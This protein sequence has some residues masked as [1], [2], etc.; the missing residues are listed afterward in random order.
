[1]THRQFLAWQAWL[2]LEWDRPSR[3]DCY[4]MQV[5]AEVRRVLAK[6]PNRIKT[7]EFKLKF[8]R[9]TPVK[10]VT[11]AEAAKAAKERSVS[12]MTAGVTRVLVDKDGNV[13][14]VTKA[15]KS[16]TTGEQQSGNGTGNREPDRPPDWRLG[17]LQED[18]SGR[19]G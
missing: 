15:E 12:R 7:N 16:G 11:R 9:A 6:N 17:G 3:G 5:A 14:S 8:D 4:Q 10:K 2:E 18:D 19:R 13:L 1:M